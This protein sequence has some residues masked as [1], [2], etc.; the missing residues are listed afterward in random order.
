MQLPLCTSRLASRLLLLRLLLLPQLLLEVG[1]AQLLLERR[2]AVVLD[3]RRRPHHVGRDYNCGHSYCRRLEVPSLR[4]PRRVALRH[5]QVDPLF[6]Q[7]GGMKRLLG[8]RPGTSRERL[9]G[10]RGLALVR[11]LHRLVGLV[12]V[13]PTLGREHSVH[14][15]LSRGLSLAASRASCGESRRYR[16]VCSLS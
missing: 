16:F 10:C 6:T 14:P 2:L 8:W 12:P 13:G 15:S 1:G 9:S 3:H 4:A 11:A 7:R 5:L